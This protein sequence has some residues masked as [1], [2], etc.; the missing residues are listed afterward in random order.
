MSNMQINGFLQGCALVGL[1]LLAACSSDNDDKVQDPVF[2]DMQTV[3]I[4][5]G[6]AQE[7]TFHADADWKLTIDKSW[8]R[9]DNDG[10]ETAQVAGKAGD[11]AVVVRVTDRNLGFESASAQI[12]MSMGAK[13]QPI[14]EIPRPGRQAE[15]KMYEKTGYGVNAKLNEL[16]KVTLTYKTRNS[17]SVNLGF[18]ANFDWL[19][20]SVPEGFTMQKIQGAA[21]E[22]KPEPTDPNFKTTTIKIADVELLPYARQDKIVISDIDGNKPQ[23]FIVEYTG[24]GDEDFFFGPGSATST[25][26]SADG[27]VYKMQGGPAAPGTETSV[28]CSVFARDMKYRAF[29]VERNGNEAEDV[30]GKSWLEVTDDGK[31]GISYQVKGG[32]MNPEALREAYLFVLPEKLAA[33]PDFNTYF[34]ANGTPKTPYGVTV[35]QED[36]PQGFAGAWGI[37]GSVPFDKFVPYAE[38][39]LG[40]DG[41]KPADRF[42]NAPE[43]STYVYTFSEKDIA[44][45]FKF[46]PLGFDRDYRPN[47]LY[48]LIPESGNW[49]RIGLSGTDV[50]LPKPYKKSVKGF[51][52]DMKTVGETGVACMLFYGDEAHKEQGVPGIALIFNKVK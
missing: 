39:A 15:A 40:Q 46:G 22:G 41:S 34:T 10:A 30:T 16:E 45:P 25:T 32:G 19:V 18:A 29:V 26:F 27:F 21:T 13:M 17:S 14:F 3:E 1:A 33:D 38:S 47:D 11:A 6:Q 7:L 48:E 51:S 8:C 24:M 43:N 23:E 36:D 2:P 35:V 50:A 12:M 4:A 42:P 20:L 28:A 37:G 49:G 9:F 31:G 5:V 44:G 52:A